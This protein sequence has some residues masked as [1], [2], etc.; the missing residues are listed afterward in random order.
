MLNAPE[1]SVGGYGL[2]SF[3]HRNGNL[4]ANVSIGSEGTY[5]WDGPGEIH[6]NVYNY[7]N[8]NWRATNYLYGTVQNYN[9]MDLYDDPTKCVDGDMF[10]YGTIKTWGTNLYVTG[11]FVNE[12]EYISDPSD[13]HFGT[14][15]V[16]RKGV[17]KGGRGD[18]FFIARDLII[19]STNALRWD[20]REASLIFE[21]HTKHVMA[22]TG[23]DLG[24][25]ASNAVANFAW[26]RLV[27]PA[28]EGLIL[29]DG[30]N[31]PGGALY[32]GELLLGGG[33][34]QLSM[35]RSNGMSLY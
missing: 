6:G 16:G 28:G 34:E 11:T 25:L 8:F 21:G 20:T 17:L 10:N 24:P 19:H 5:S 18:R 15:I 32:V 7:G 31:K 13:N 2:G 29:I 22:I 23:D 27:L 14:L 12:G 3:W 30:D 35:I 26:G 1:I 4:N 33:L 9:R